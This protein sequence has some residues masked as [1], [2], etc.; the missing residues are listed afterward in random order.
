MRFS[1]GT[2][3]GHAMSVRVAPA[4]ARASPAPTP[5]SESAR[6]GYCRHGGRF[7][8]PCRERAWCISPSTLLLRPY[9][10]IR[11]GNSTID[12]SGVPNQPG[13]ALDIVDET[14][15]NGSPDWAV[16]TRFD[17]TTHRELLLG[18]KKPAG[19]GSFAGVCEPGRMCGA[20]SV[21]PGARP[22][23]RESQGSQCA[24]RPRP[25]DRAAPTA[26]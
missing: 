15:P 6:D 23:R 9:R 10:P 24:A 7:L 19:A 3:S 8:G 4:I 25:R 1:I 2:S 20:P 14:R 17:P 13:L 11:W 12:R 18:D 22:S 21:P 16:G 26:A 5:F